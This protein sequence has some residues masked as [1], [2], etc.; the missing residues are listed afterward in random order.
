M[1]TSA[2]FKGRAQKKW[3]TENRFVTWDAC[4]VCRSRVQGSKSLF[5]NLVF[6]FKHFMRF[7]IFMPCGD[8]IVCDGLNI[9]DLI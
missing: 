6:V 8:S 7:L 9:L 4:I 5:V 1:H 2:K 3:E